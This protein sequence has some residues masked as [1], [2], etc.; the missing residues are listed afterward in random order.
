MMKCEHDWVVSVDNDD[1]PEDVMCSSCEEIFIFKDE[2][3]ERIAN[4]LESLVEN[5]VKINRSLNRDN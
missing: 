2:V 1:I 3:Q 5:S 4:A